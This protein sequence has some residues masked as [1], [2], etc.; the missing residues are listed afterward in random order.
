MDPK[1][2]PPLLKA[3]AK[4]IINLNDVII[5]PVAIFDENETCIISNSKTIRNNSLITRK[6]PVEEHKS[7][8]Q[9]ELQNN[10]C[11]FYVCEFKSRLIGMI[12]FDTDND[13]AVVSIAIKDGYR[14]KGIGTILFNKV[15]A[16]LKNS[17]PAL[18]KI[19]AYIKINNKKSINF[20]SKINFNFK[21]VI[22][23]KNIEVYRYVLNTKKL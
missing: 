22:M 9:K 21:D 3:M 4:T 2:S 15:L 7:W 23:I 20:F 5:R 6:I 12:R 10:K 1:N 14:N 17:H 16:S 13:Y 11:V 19:Y 8:F 18:K